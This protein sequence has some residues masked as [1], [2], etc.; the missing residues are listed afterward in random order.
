LVL[1]SQRSLDEWANGSEEVAP[2]D[3]RIF[4]MNDAIALPGLFPF[5]QGK[6][7]DAENLCIQF[8]DQKISMTPS[9]EIDL[10]VGLLPNVSLATSDFVTTV[11]G[12]LGISPIPSVFLT[13]VV[14]AQ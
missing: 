8:K 2:L 1:F 14:K 13:Q 6:E 4:D 12:A 11:C 7:C 3:P 9:G 10:G 5:N